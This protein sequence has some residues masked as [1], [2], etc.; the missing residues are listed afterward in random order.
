MTPAP[1]VCGV[2]SAAGNTV[3]DPHAARKRQ[4]LQCATVRPK[5]ARGWQE[6]G[7]TEH[8]VQLYERDAALLANLGPYVAEALRCRECA[9]VIATEAHRRALEAWLVAAGIDVAAA[10]A[11]RAL[12]LLDA[13]VMLQRFLIGGMPDAEL[14]DLTVG[15]MIRTAG[16]TGRPVRAYGE[17]VSLL[18]AAGNQRAA[19]RLE[20]FWNELGTQARFSLFC[21]YPSGC[22]G[23]DKGQDALFAVCA[24]HTRVIPVESVA[25]S[26]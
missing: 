15:S 6:T 9:I 14:F 13:H 3:D 21:A 1:T 26:A 20:E 25:S 23:D 4:V 5:L 7:R 17:M 2:S 11:A 8:F 19:L 24:A 22:F 18:L 16:R 12:T 10:Q